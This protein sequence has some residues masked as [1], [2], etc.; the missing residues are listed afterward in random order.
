MCIGVFD[1]EISC[2]SPLYLMKF[3]R[4]CTCQQQS[5]CRVTVGLETE[6]ALGIVHMAAFLVSPEEEV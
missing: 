1:V 6:I 3:E 5:R 4:M 2:V